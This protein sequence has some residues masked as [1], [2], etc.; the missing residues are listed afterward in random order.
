[1]L[2]VFIHLLVQTSSTPRTSHP[3]LDASTLE[4]HLGEVVDGVLEIGIDGV[5]LSSALSH[6][7]CGSNGNQ[8]IGEGIGVRLESCKVVLDAGRKASRDEL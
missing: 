8:S 2:Y 1:M 4:P 6:G 5:L 3:I 7:V